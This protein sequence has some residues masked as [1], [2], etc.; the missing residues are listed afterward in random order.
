MRTKGLTLGL[1]TLTLAVA[2]VFLVPNTALTA[3]AGEKAAAETEARTEPVEDISHL[4]ERIDESTEV[5]QTMLA[6]TD[7]RIPPQFVKD[8]AGIAIFPDMTKVAVG[9][10]GRHGGG[11]LML[12]QNGE[13]TGPIFLSLYGASVGMQIGAEETD[14][15]MVFTT[16]KGL[17]EFSDG[18]LQLGAEASVAAGMYGAKVGAATEADVMVYK[19]TSGLFAGAAL[20]GAILDAD[21]ENNRV[22]F[23]KE[24][25]RKRAYYGQEKLLSGKEDIPKTEQAKQL[26]DMLKQYTRQE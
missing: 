21:D 2:V 14:L 12:N 10:G 5:L 23:E 8:A 17:D 15:V 3:G 22:Y 11:V 1:L 16:R 19:Q 24:S 20:S 25:D 13:W 6:R 4:R 7:E 18:E 9:F 26:I